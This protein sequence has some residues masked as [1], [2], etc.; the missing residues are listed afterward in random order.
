MPRIVCSPCQTV[1]VRG[2]SLPSREL[3]IVVEGG[4]AVGIAA[5]LGNK[6][7]DRG[8][9]LTI[10]VSGGNVDQPLLAEIMTSRG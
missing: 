7:K 3:K 8:A 2:E 6:L 10:V 1:N 5:I 4:G 9:N